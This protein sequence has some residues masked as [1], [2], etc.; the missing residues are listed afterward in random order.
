MK[1][2]F[3]TCPGCGFEGD[4]I[5]S[6]NEVLKCKCDTVLEKQNEIG[7]AHV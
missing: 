1:A 4:R 2:Y 3:C 5:V 7:R 6:G